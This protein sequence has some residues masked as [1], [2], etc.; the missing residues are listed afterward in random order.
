MQYLMEEKSLPDSILSVNILSKLGIDRH[1][2]YSHI[3]VL[4]AD[5]CSRSDIPETVT[6]IISV[7]S[8]LYAL[9]IMYML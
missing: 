9:C 3:I 1:L 7:Y 5:V 6:V 2:F 4:L 8:P